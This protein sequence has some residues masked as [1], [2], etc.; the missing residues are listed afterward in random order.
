TSVWGRHA[1]IRALAHKRHRWQIAPVLL[2]FCACSAGTIVGEWRLA[3]T[4]GHTPPLGVAGTAGSRQRT[5][6]KTK[7]GGAT[8]PGNIG[9]AASKIGR[10]TSRPSLRR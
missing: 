7:A 9:A 1:E 5:G 3:R 2:D 8:N 4:A 10:P 6:Q